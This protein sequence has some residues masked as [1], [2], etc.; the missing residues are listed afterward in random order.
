MK[1]AYL[2][3]LGVA[4]SFLLAAALANKPWLFYLLRYPDTFTTQSV[5]GVILHTLF[6][7]ALTSVMG[8]SFLGLG[9]YLLE[10]LGCNPDECLEGRLA[11]V[12]LGFGITA[13][14]VGVLGVAGCY[15]VR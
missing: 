3:W 6:P 8:L 5:K 1:K 10:A 2:P 12:A 7:L 15:R 13:I 4:G 9:C 14:T 11:A